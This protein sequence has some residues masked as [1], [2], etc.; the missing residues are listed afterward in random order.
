MDSLLPVLLAA[1]GVMGG[2]D[3]VLNHELIAKLPQ[4]P[5]ARGEIGLHSI[6]EAIYAFLFGGLAWFAWE[7]AAAWMLAALLVA[8]VVNTACD[9]WTE[10]RIRVLPQNERV[11]HIFLTLNLGAIIALLVPTIGEWSA[12]PTGFSPRN[13]GPLSWLLTAF[14][15]LGVFWSLRDALAWRKLR[16]K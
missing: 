7:G 5:E 8:E 4:R 1:Q 9:E 12:A 10:N 11:L 6:R 15:L 13:H 14:S 16:A 3:T 2:V